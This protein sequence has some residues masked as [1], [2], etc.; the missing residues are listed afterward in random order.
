MSD[1]NNHVENIEP[2]VQLVLLLVG[3]TLSIMGWLIDWRGYVQG[4]GSGMCIILAVWNGFAIVKLLT[5]NNNG[6][7]KQ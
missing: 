1:K 4:V 7:D 6:K 5:P 2:V 3:I